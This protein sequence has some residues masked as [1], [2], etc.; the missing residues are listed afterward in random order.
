MA[1]TVAIQ[2]HDS[3]TEE[4]S[5]PQELGRVRSLHL[6]ANRSGWRL[7]TAAQT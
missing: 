7:A 6:S 2:R 1:A 3:A 5:D 4:V